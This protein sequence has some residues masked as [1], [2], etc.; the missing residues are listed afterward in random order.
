[1]VDDSTPTYLIRVEKIIEEERNRIHSYLNLITES[2]LFHVLDTV[3]IESKLTIL[4]D[5]EG[6]GLRVLL[7]NDRLEDIMR[8]FTLFNRLKGG[9]GVNMMADI[10][11]EYIIQLGNDIILERKMKLDTLAVQ[12]ASASAT[13][14]AA[15]A[16][17]GSSKGKEKAGAPAGG[18]A[19]AAGEK[20]NSE[21]ESYLI[22]IQYLK[23]VM[24]IHEKYLTLIKNSLQ[25]HPSFHKSIKDS[26]TT[27]LNKDIMSKEI[28]NIQIL[29]L[30]CDNILKTN[31]Y[32]KIPSENEIEIYLEKMVQLF[33]YLTDKDLFNEIYRNLLAKRLLSQRSSSD[34]MERLVNDFE[35][36]IKMWLTIHFKD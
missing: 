14:A 31:S 32:E 27:L 35:I 36:E 7:Q 6:S 19:A 16:P 10:L 23:D 3:L 11:R 12:K 33:T 20:L 5:K 30:F 4:I 24:A 21:K 17:E 15:A 1:M 9:I 8:M 29:N 26:F 28:N 22:D 25:N 2:K 18:A 13:P 34:D